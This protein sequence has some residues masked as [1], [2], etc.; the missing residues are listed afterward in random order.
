MF[1]KRNILDFLAFCSIGLLIYSCANRGYPTGG[2]KDEN[3]PV[4]VKEDPVNGSTNF[5]QAYA[6]LLAK[7]SSKIKTTIG[8]HKYKFL[9][10]GD[11][12]FH[13]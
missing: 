8:V 9:F 12:F 4:I 11:K 13:E 10:L 2:P 1:S 6:Q 7:L 5:F 3:P